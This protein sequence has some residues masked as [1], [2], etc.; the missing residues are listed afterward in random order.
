MDSE[1]N[2]GLLT[3]GT[4]WDA[5]QQTLYYIHNFFL[6]EYKGTLTEASL[7]L[8]SPAASL[9]ILLMIGETLVGPYN[10]ILGRQFWYA[11]TTPWISDQR[12]H[13]AK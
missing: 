9:A 12:K 4:Q 2:Q 5:Q 8:P 3:L 10:W 13:R 7:M 6:I 11:S 1:V